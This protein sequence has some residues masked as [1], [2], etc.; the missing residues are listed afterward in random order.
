MEAGKQGSH[1]PVLWKAGGR[2]E[3]GFISLKVGLSFVANKR[4]GRFLIFCFFLGVQGSDKVQHYHH[5]L[6]NGPKV[7]F[8]FF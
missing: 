2:M 6:L 4:V 3:K 1:Q 8:S 7:S 5:S